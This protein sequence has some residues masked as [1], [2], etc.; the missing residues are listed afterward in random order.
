MGSNLAK[1][2]FDQKQAMKYNS[3]LKLACPKSEN[4]I[5]CI[6]CAYFVHL[7]HVSVQFTKQNVTKILKAEM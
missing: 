2:K 7:Q 4:I 3:K 1:P 6:V 5:V